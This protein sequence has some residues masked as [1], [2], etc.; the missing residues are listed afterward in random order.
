MPITGAPSTR[1]ERTALEQ[2]SECN[3]SLAL[4]TPLAAP[5]VA[6][7]VCDQCGAAY[8]ADRATEEGSAHEPGARQVPFELLMQSISGRLEEKTVAIRAKDVERLIQ[9]LSGRAY[10]GEEKRNQTRYRVAAPIVVVPLAGNFRIAGKPVR[11]VLTSVSCGGAAFMSAT[12]IADRFV[13]VDFSTAGVDLLPAVMQVSRIQ[14]LQ[15]AFTVAGQF[16]SRV[17]PAN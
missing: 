6:P 1:I 10:T 13:L 16:L 9:C 17:R 5:M 11:T 7:W 3:Q 2:C 12:R 14:P 4:L 8:L 15:H